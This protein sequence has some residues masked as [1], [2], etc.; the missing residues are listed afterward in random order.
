M[1]SALSCQQRIAGLAATVPH[2]RQQCI[3]GLATTV[4]Q[5]TTGSRIACL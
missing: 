2:K 1:R 3:A 4:P 5:L